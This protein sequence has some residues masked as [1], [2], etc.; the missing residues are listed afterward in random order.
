M[1]SN[2]FTR[3]NNNNDNDDDNNTDDNN[4]PAV[5]KRRKSNDSDSGGARAYGSGPGPR[6]HAPMSAALSKVE[7]VFLPHPQDAANIKELRH[8]YV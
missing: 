6:S 5:K 1:T 4:R 7:L 2:R 3:N 8:K